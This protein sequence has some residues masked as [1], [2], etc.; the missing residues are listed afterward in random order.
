MIYQPSIEDFLVAV[1]LTVIVVL[2]WHTKELKRSSLETEKVLKEM[3]QT[4][5]EVHGD[6]KKLLVAVDRLE[7]DIAKMKKS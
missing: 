7:K 1:E 3:D 5:T 2:L 4:H 6:M